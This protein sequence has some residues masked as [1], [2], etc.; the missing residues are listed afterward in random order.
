MSPYLLCPQGNSTII[1]RW[2]V[3]CAAVHPKQRVLYAVIARIL[4]SLAGK[5]HQVQIYGLYIVARI[6][7]QQTLPYT[8]FMSAYS[9]LQMLRA[10]H[11]I[12]LRNEITQAEPCKRTK[13]RQQLQ[14]CQFSATALNS[15][16]VTAQLHSRVKTTSGLNPF[17]TDELV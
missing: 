11:V 6:P 12:F 15:I 5:K 1:C 8:Q 7:L 13:W 16:K 4:H 9:F 17:A 14:Q 3:L 10:F 2:A